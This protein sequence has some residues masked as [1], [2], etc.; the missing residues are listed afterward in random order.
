MAPSDRPGGILGRLGGILVRKRWPTWLQLGAQN[1]GKFHLK[2]TQKM[3]K[4][5]MPLE[6]DFLKI[7][8]DLGRQNGAK[9]A[10]KSH[11]KSI[12]TSKGDF[13]KKPCFSKGKTMILKVLGVEVGTK[14]RSKIDQKMKSSWEGILASIFHGFWSILEAKL[15][16]SWGRKSIKNRSKKALKNRWQKEDD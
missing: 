1:G 5:L 15:G 7:L 14:N 3:I 11:Q 2:T 4:I 12:P 10:P 16:P 13:L 9:L 6:I 8:V